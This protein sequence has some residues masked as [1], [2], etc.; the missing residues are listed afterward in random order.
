[1]A[2]D[3][4]DVTVGNRIRLRRK[5][6]GLSQSALA[7]H[8]GVS[9]QQVQKYERGANR[10]SASMLVRVG[11]KLQMTVAD[12]VG[13]ASGSVTD[14]EL[15]GLLS[16]PG[17]TELVAAFSKVQSPGVRR[18]II[19]MVRAVALHEPDGDVSI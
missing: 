16:S 19:D 2:S 4:I 11:D 9:F 7:E 17:V 8:L 1:M 15:L 12:L 6:L 5:H 18:G 14:S 3:P 13:E 10:V